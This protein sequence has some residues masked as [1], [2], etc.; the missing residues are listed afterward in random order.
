MPSDA[1]NAVVQSI[2][3]I[4]GTLSIIAVSV[5][6]YK[7]S[8]ET[9]AK[10]TSSLMIRAL[11]VF[12]LILCIFF[13]VGRAGK[14]SAGFCQ[15]QALMIQWF[16]TAVMLWVILLS[17]TMYEWVV[18]RK[19]L[20]R[21][22]KIV[23]RSI[24]AIFCASGLLAFLLLGLGAYGEVYLWCWISEEHADYRIF[25]FDLILLASWAIGL[26]V[27]HLVSQSVGERI[28]SSKLHE[29]INI[30]LGSSNFSVEKKLSLY[31]GSFILIWF[32]ALLNRSVETGLGHT[33]LPTAVL[34]A[35]F[36]PLQGLINA[37]L[38]GNVVNIRKLLMVEDFRKVFLGVQATHHS[39]LTESIVEHRPVSVRGI[40][41]ATIQQQQIIY[42]PKQ[43][44]IF[45]TTLNMG[46]ATL[47]SFY[48]DVKDWI[49]AG[50][51]IYAIGLQECI[52]LAGLRE[53]VLNHLGGPSKY[54]MYTTSIGSGNTSLGYH[55]YIA[56]TLYVKQTEIIAGNI[57]ATKPA[58]EA[59]ATGTDLII[60]TAQ[61]KGAV[62]IALHIHD[63]SIGFV[64]CHLPSDS[65]G[66]SKLSKR[67]ASAHAILKQVILASEDLGFDLHQ[68]HDHVFVFGDLN[69]RMDTTGAGG[70]VNSL[71]GVAVACGIEKSTLQDDINWLAR[72]YNLLRHH[73]DVLYPSLDEVKL[74][75]D[76]LSGS[77]GAWG[78]VLRADEL[79]SIMDDGD[80]F[81]GFE[82]PMPCFPPSYKRRKGKVEGDCGDYTDFAGIIRGYSNTGDVENMLMNKPKQIN[83]LERVQQFMTQ[84][85][86][87]LSAKLSGND[88][89]NLQNQLG[90]KEKARGRSSSGAGSGGSGGRASPS[91]FNR[92]NSADAGEKGR[93]ISTEEMEVRASDS[94]GE[95]IEPEDDVEASP[96]SGKARTNRRKAL[97]TAGGVEATSTKKE[98]DPSKLRPP[99]YTDRILLHSLPDR[100]ER[101]TVQGYDFCDT[102][103]CSDHRAVSMTVLLEV[104]SS[105]AFGAPK[106]IDYDY[107]PLT[108]RQ[109]A[110]PAPLHR[111]P[112]FELYEVL[113]SDLHVTLFDLQDVEEEEDEEEAVFRDTI[114]DSP[115]SSPT[116][117]MLNRMSSGRTASGRFVSNP[118]RSTS[119]SASTS[120]RSS[121]ALPALPAPEEKETSP[122][123]KKKK[124]GVRFDDE[125]AIE[126]P[127]LS[128]DFSPIVSHDTTSTASAGSVGSVDEAPATEVM[129]ADTV[130]RFVP[131]APAAP[132]DSSPPPPR[133]IAKNKSTRRR[134]FFSVFFSSEPESESDLEAGKTSA[135]TNVEDE[136][137]KGQELIK[138]LSR[139]NMD[140]KNKLHKP[141]EWRKRKL[142][143]QRRQKEANANSLQHI[144]GD[145]RKASKKA[146]K[147]DDK[148]IHQVTVVFPL[149]S[150]DPLLAHR[151]VYDYAQVFETSDNIMDI[152]QHP[153]MD[154]TSITKEELLRP[155][156]IFAW[157]TSSFS[158]CNVYSD[159]TTGTINPMQAN[160]LTNRN[161]IG[162]V[163]SHTQTIFGS[164]DSYKVKG[165]ASVELGAHVLLKLSNKAG[166]EFGSS[167][168]CLNQLLHNDPNTLYSSH[169]KEVSSCHCSIPSC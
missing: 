76:A 54:A 109:T 136:K 112:V 44:S 84:T 5:V 158:T 113:I 97:V 11:C 69:Y 142:E 116:P 77:R 56:L 22:E 65:K 1:A 128:T 80:A 135:Q 8:Q 50:H 147:S 82:E 35:I 61:N 9:N 13:A 90:I 2:E 28:Q 110:A 26:G 14:V 150:K 99:S 36:L 103:R 132:T 131:L 154:M 78:S 125:K 92:S 93:S 67:N 70:G 139:E 45:I 107:S 71:T 58:A 161:S 130:N 121:R 32:F 81:C 72:K 21:M 86:R 95:G 59:A 83:A 18:L 167:V 12:D 62:G 17:Y 89:R 120:D 27:L 20:K 66:K 152:Q 157:S 102:V 140:W 94:N 169:I 163:A 168:I 52:D 68:Q 73:T 6:L 118:M 129:V 104:N 123:S 41:A 85:H 29:S 4:G 134:S 145:I 3:T 143:E 74:I 16:S 46:E 53:L 64:T 156:S 162:S 88:L 106:S 47:E 164:T 108:D 98:V 57:Y 122:M 55:G 101:V 40:P 155:F 51:D 37:L 105:V 160:A 124:G 31:I 96:K 25:G 127:T 48:G 146:K 60:T 137:R 24:I 149:P 15:F 111:E 148:N 19:H 30:M 117:S 126:L 159:K 165:C 87:P 75:K 10:S 115:E 144:A 91:E 43:Y 79:R 133:Q 49:V 100:Q 34:Q 63:T 42:T 23:R 39:Q 114:V 7:I 119:S 151:K 38:F 166:Y 141:N 153:A 33:F 138:E